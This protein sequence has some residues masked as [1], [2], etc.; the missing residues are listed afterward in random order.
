M[1]SRASLRLARRRRAVPLGH[2]I[3]KGDEMAIKREKIQ[4]QGI[5]VSMVDGKARLS[6]MIR[7][8][9]TDACVKLRAA[10]ARPYRLDIGRGRL[11]P[12]ASSSTLVVSSPTSI[13]W[14]SSATSGSSR[15]MM[16]GPPSMTSLGYR[17]DDR[18]VPSRGRY[19]RR[20]ARSGAQPRC[21]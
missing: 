9:S 8:P 13:C 16:R 15:L 17:N 3:G 20:R 2:I 12:R 1:T 7:K 5:H 6:L 19:S 14:I 10:G 18:P 21:G 11:Q 4:P